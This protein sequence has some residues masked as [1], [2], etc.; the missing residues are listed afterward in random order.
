MAA[1]TLVWLLRRDAPRC[2]GRS[3]ILL[4]AACLDCRAAARLLRKANW[5]PTLLPCLAVTCFALG[6]HK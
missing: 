2:A 5:L 4:P 1:Y 3:G 6:P